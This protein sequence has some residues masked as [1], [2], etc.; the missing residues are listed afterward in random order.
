MR[1]RPNV[2]IAAESN[3]VGADQGEFVLQ[4]RL[5]SYA[6]MFMMRY[7]CSERFGNKWTLHIMKHVSRCSM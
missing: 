7:T 4:Y 3:L 5:I 6:R 2:S 1:N